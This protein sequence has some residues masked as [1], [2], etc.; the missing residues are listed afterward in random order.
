MSEPV[1]ET[2]QARKSFLLEYFQEPETTEWRGV[3]WL[4]KGLALLLFAA[5]LLD[6]MGTENGG[7][8]CALLLIVPGGALAA[9]SLNGL[10][11]AFNSKKCFV[12]FAEKKDR[13]VEQLLEQD[14]SGIR[15]YA[16]ATLGIDEDELKIEPLVFPNPILWPLETLD[17]EYKLVRFGAE[18]RLR[19]GAYNAA[20]LAVGEQ[21][22]GVFHC[23]LNFVLGTMLRT[24]AKEFRFTEISSI[25]T[26]EEARVVS[27]PIGDQKTRIR[28]IE[29]VATSGES[30]RV[31]VEM[32]DLWQVPGY[33]GAPGDSTEKALRAIRTAMRG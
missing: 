3:G 21:V 11:N 2:D 12:Q 13:R 5:L 7:L 31:M 9:A 18:G 15:N 28:G 6:A 4:I 27:L 24:E 10:I 1:F 16:L 14:L 8:G 33:D 19:S 32:P 25:A 22:L 26:L 17:E 29:V 20:V 30:M 23:E